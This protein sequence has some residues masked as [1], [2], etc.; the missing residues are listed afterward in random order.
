MHTLH[1]LLFTKRCTCY[2]V[3]LWSDQPS[4]QLLWVL[5]Q[6]IFCGWEFKRRMFENLKFG[7][8]RFKTCVLEKHFISYSCILFLI[9]NVLRSFFKIQVMFF[10]NSV[11]SEFRSIQSV[12]QSIE[13]AFKILCELLSV[14][15]NR[16]SWI[17]FLKN[18]IWLVQ[19]NYFKTFQNFFLSLRLGKAPQR[20]FV[21][22]DQISCKVSLSLSW[23][24]YITLPFALIFTFSCIISWFLGNFRTMHNLGFFD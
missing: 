4:L 3:C 12:F 11:F 15:I 14:S 21:I 17:R 24:V 22:F 10:K 18:Q 16:N 5:V 9:F 20:F 13:I 23:Y 6:N 8:T 2:C 19:T 7:K 1:K